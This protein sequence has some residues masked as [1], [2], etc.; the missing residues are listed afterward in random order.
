MANS[1]RT[2][3][4][5]DNLDSPLAVPKAPADPQADL[6]NRIIP[7]STGE[8]RDDPMGFLRDLEPKGRKR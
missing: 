3:G 4:T 1:E 8:L 7:G 6:D 2:D 5:F